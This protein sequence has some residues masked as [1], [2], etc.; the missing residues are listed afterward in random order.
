M[1]SLSPSKLFS[2][3]WSRELAAAKRMDKKTAGRKIRLRLFGGMLFIIVLKFK[4][5]RVN[6]NLFFPKL[7]SN[8]KIFIRKNFLSQLDFRRT[9]E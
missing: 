7:Q 6:S 4:F 5:F 1:L 2:A 9:I 8:H 3:S